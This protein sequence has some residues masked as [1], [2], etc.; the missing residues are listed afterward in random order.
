MPQETGPPAGPR[1]VTHHIQTGPPYHMGTVYDPGTFF[2]IKY[3]AF[4]RND[5]I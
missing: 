5:I 3:R 2:L 4:S 1:V